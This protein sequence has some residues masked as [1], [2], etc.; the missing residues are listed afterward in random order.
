MPFNYPV[1][2]EPVVPGEPQIQDELEVYW[3]DAMEVTL[4]LN[5]LD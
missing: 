4:T 2:E 5:L 1:P 3:D